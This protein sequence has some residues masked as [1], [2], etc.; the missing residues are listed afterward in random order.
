M[1]YKPAINIYGVDSF[2]KY[3]VESVLADIP[4]RMPLEPGQAIPQIDIWIISQKCLTDVL[5][6]VNRPK[7]K[8]PSI[9]FVLNAANVCYKVPLP[10]GA[11]ACSIWI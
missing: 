4:L 5:P 1:K 6:F 9:V 2:F 10:T 11:F 3:G 8:T 7:P